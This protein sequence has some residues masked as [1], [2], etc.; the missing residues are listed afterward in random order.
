M[1]LGQRHSE[2][3]AFLKHLAGCFSYHDDLINNLCLVVTKVE[4]L[5]LDSLRSGFF[6]IAE[7]LSDDTSTQFQKRL[8]VAWGNPVTSRIGL[9][10]APKMSGPNLNEDRTQIS[11]ILEKTSSIR[12]LETKFM[13]NL[14]KTD[15]AKE[16]D[17]KCLRI[18]LIIKKKF[19]LFVLYSFKK[20]WD[21]Y[22]THC[23]KQLER[24]SSNSET[25][26]QRI[27]E[28][29]DLIENNSESEIG[30]R[31][32]NLANKTGFSLY[33]LKAANDFR[34]PVK[35]NYLFT[36]IDFWNKKTN[37]YYNGYNEVSKNCSNCQ[38]PGLD[39]GNHDCF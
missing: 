8:L 3:L 17:E 4:R 36:N 27:I 35:F 24:I 28:F 22:S 5:T 6:S 33:E 19:E 34:T 15:F 30:E 20:I 29:N 13:E 23:I 7:S 1:I 26:I 11:Q 14:K 37:E 31:K 12:L 16:L 32:V 38:R 39:F 2:F 9:F 21:N 18:E 10:H 25:D